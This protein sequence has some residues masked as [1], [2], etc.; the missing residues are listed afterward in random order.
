[1]YP[2]LHNINFLL[3]S[4]SNIISCVHHFY[5]KIFPLILIFK[6]NSCVAPLVHKIH[7]KNSASASYFKI[8]YQFWS[9]FSLDVVRRCVW[10]QMR[11]IIITYASI[12]NI[13]FF[14]SF[15]KKIF[16]MMEDNQKKVPNF[17]S[18]GYFPEL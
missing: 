4:L 18:L 12:A 10:P 5:S 16:T 7:R 13:D 14:G 6:K 9:Q 11:L 17:V 3:I 8:H 1:M 15:R 2:H